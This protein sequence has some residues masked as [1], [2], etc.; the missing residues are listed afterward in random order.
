MTNTTQTA[1]K[2]IEEMSH[3]EL[4]N[5]AE[6]VGRKYQ[7]KPSK[8]GDAAEIVTKAIVG[9]AFHA[10]DSGRIVRRWWDAG[11]FHQAAGAVAKAVRIMWATALALFAM[12]QRRWVST[13]EQRLQLAAFARACSKACR[14]RAQKVWQ[15]SRA[16]MVPAVVAAPVEIAERYLRSYDG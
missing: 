14:R 13:K 3:E 10:I 9:L 8:D 6:V 16:V 4:F 7:S 2:P 11:Y 12:A 5:Y 1:A 15:W